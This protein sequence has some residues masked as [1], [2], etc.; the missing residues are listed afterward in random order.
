M[1][2]STQSRVSIPLF[3]LPIV[4]ERIGPLLGLVKKD[5]LADYR[6]VLWQDYMD[7]FYGTA[8]EGKK[9][10]EFAKINFAQ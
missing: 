7:N 1:T 6:E 5:E 8:H 3:T 2:T 10:I 4:T 9:T